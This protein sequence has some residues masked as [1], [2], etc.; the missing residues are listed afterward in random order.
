MRDITITVKYFNELD[1]D[2][3][4]RL[5]ERYQYIN[6][7]DGWWY[8]GRRQTCMEALAEL[9]YNDCS[10]T[11]PDLQA[12]VGEVSISIDGG[13]DFQAVGKRLVPRH[14]QCYLNYLVDHGCLQF[15]I[16]SQEPEVL[17]SEDELA[18][19]QL[20][21]TADLLFSNMEN[22]LRNER[23]EL[24]QTFKQDYDYL[25]SDEQVKETLIA[26]E[27]EFSPKTLD[28]FTE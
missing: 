20:Q 19:E 28:I 27:Y 8:D 24:Y 17:L 18:Q 10:F 4:Q 12:S 15:S 1:A 6:V 21:A 3:Q 13:V 23:G 5:I 14:L 11:I 9:G 26:N 25:I 22:E 7:Q 16:R 2:E